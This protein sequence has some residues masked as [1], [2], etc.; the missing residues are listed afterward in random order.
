MHLIDAVCFL[1]RAINHFFFLK[2]VVAV[3]V[4]AVSK[5]GF[6][7]AQKFQFSVIHAYNRLIVVAAAG[8]V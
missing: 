3:R 2:I 1:H 6:A 8:Y 5:I 7:L 4:N